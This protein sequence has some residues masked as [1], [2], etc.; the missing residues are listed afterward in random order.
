MGHT[1]AKV[2]LINTEKAT[3]S[4]SNGEIYSEVIVV[5]WRKLMNM[6]NVLKYQP[7]VLMDKTIAGTGWDRELRILLGLGPEQLLEME[8]FGEQ[9]EYLEKI[10]A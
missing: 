8:K 7:T 1:S 10:P 2:G 6:M 4:L 3:Q 9:K 5:K